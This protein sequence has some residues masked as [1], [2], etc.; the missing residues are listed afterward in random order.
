M[1]GGTKL[2]DAILLL[3]AG[4]KIQARQLLAEVLREDPA[5]A[6]AWIGLSFCV[7]TSEQRRDCLARALAINPDNQY[8]KSA[9][10]RLGQSQPATALEPALQ[11][12][13]VLS[14]ANLPQSAAKTWSQKQ[15]TTALIGIILTVLFILVVIGLVVS[16][17]AGGMEV[18]SDGSLQ[19]TSGKYQ[20]VEFY[21]DWCTYCKKM[22]PIV[23]DLAR[24][25]AGD[26]QFVYLNLDDPANNAASRRFGVNSV[27][28]FYF[29][30]P[31]GNVVRQWI[32]AVP[33][34]EFAPVLEK[35]DS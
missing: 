21:A 33:A 25:C 32:G 1:A 17:N 15:V 27:P 18:A 30:D 4:N 10:A 20:F 8:A 29:L 16:A 22:R 13:Q 24:E 3:K 12:A 6:E 23:A 7:D 28:R 2:Q 26:V 34:S 5:Q 35:C 11:P 19:N 31:N 14:P 9:F